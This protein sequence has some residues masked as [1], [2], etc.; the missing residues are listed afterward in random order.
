MKEENKVELLAPAG[1]MEGFYGAIHAGADAVYLAGEQF[2]ARAY[3]DNFTT[4]EILTCIRYAH[5]L[6]RKVYLAV[7]TLIKEKEF[8]ILHD[9]LLPFYEAGLD[10][11]IVQDLGAFT[12]IKEFFPGLS[13]HVSTQMTITGV[14]GAKLL[15][16]MG[17][18]RIVPAR[19]LSLLE[20]CNLKQQTGLE[21]ECFIHGSMC[22]CYSGQCLFSS[23]LGGRSGNRGRCAQPCRLPYMV[24]TKEGLSKQCYPLSLKDMC[25]IEHLPRLIQSGIDSFKIEGRMKKP[26]YT[27][28]VT[29]IYRK[30]IDNYY[31]EGVKISPLP[32]RCSLSNEDKKALTS[33]YIRSERQDG[34]Y[35]RKNGRDMLA[36]NHPS[37]N[38]SDEKLLGSIRKDYLESKLRIPVVL[39]AD[40]V[41]MEPARLTVEAAGS[42]CTIEGEP[43]QKAQNQPV[44]KE[45]IK[46]Q[47][48]KLGDSNFFLD[49]LSLH[50]DKDIFIPI[51][52]INELR[53]KAIAALEASL[54]KAN[55]FPLD[56][57]APVNKMELTQK[58]QLPSKEKKEKQM[59]VSVQTM[60][61]AK[62]LFRFIQDNPGSSIGR[63]YVDGDLFLSEQNCK[64]ILTAGQWLPGNIRMMIKLPYILRQSDENY[65]ERIY[66]LFKEHSGQIKGFLVSSME[67][68][69]FL[70]EK[71]ASGCIYTD[72]GFYFWNATAI[73]PLQQKTTGF[74]LPYE[75]KEGEQLA[76][77]SQ[78]STACEKIIYGRIPMMYSANC[79]AKTM[80]EEL[81][82]KNRPNK[83]K[84]APYYLVDRYHKRFPVQIN[85][86]HCMNIIYNSV[87]L[88]LHGF[89]SKWRN[90]ADLRLDFT[91]EDAKEVSEI[92]KFFTK[93]SHETSVSEKLTPPYKEYTTGHE[94]RGVE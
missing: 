62:A 36:L 7:N 51:K 80:G 14:H 42:S 28:G 5:I 8:P 72:A 23:I 4:E 55:G 33:L 13:L 22:Y 3:A 67:A 11:V 57:K 64:D 18:E 50:A 75:L 69:G 54:I 6:G 16:E 60:E 9:F 76:L 70:L 12:Y 24:E 58:N 66:R 56:K 94:N 71:K 85:C 48:C 47:L 81:C 78:V 61:Q 73:K 77:V 53:R 89:L 41:C 21:I 29:A 87:P 15:K 52:A 90:K 93:I 39:K 43:V 38:G 86:N 17:A 30:Y 74:C 27:A 82:N 35:F 34:Y 20:I 63:I 79:V 44:T 37:Y 19:E 45:N 32:V 49:T 84:T 2:G 31:A 91:V 59:A 25:T 26:E 92:L 68:L 83:E 1:N 10:A 46:K 40:F 88:S 65:L